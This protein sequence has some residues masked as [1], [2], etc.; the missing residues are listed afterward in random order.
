M[1]LKTEDRIKTHDLIVFIFIVFL[2]FNYSS[3]WA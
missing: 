3:W 2:A 1:Y